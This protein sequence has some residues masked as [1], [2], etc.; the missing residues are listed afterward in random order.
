MNSHIKPYIQLARLD[1]PAGFLLLYWPCA[2]SIILASDSAA[3]LYYNLFLF[4]LGAISMRGAGCVINDIYDRRIDA[5]V[6]RTRDRP[7]ASGR[8]KPVNALVL[9]LIL[10]LAG[11]YVFLHINNFAKLL[12]LGAL[13]LAMVYPLMKR[14][15]SFPQL[16]LGIT[17]NSGALIGWAAASG[18]MDFSS[19]IL[20]LGGIF[21]TMGYDTIYAHQ[22]KRDDIKA[23]VRSTAIS[24]GRNSRNIMRFFL[25]LSYI[26]IAYAAGLHY[27]PETYIYCLPALL[28]MHLIMLDVDLDDAAD[29]MNKFRQMAFITGILFALGLY[30]SKIT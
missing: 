16:F 9:L 17:F 23:G 30:I 24:F 27:G 4:L 28:H 13:L 22:D 6:E 20:Y 14:I 15:F 11:F 21:W 2:W 3:T 12:S 8:L 5:Q 29:C 1:K 18:K 7:L 25:L 19:F 26:F 10:L